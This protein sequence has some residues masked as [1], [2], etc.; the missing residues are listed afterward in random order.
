M[1]C[2]GVRMDARRLPL[3]VDHA[4][5]G[6]GKALAADVAA[7][8]VTEPGPV[9]WQCHALCIPPHLL[10]VRYRRPCAVYPLWRC[11]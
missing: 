5:G 9:L 1:S 11:R 8:A 6:V 10:P 3:L 4:H 2:T 7:V